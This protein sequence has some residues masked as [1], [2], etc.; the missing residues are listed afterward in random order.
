MHSPVFGATLIH[1]PVSRVHRLRQAPIIA[2]VAL[3]VGIRGW[4]DPGEQEVGVEGG[5]RQRIGAD[6]HAR[7]HLGVP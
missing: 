3:L 6:G 4:D 1:Q 7:R 5:L 2:E